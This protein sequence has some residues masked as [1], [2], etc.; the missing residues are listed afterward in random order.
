MQESDQPATDRDFLLWLLD[1]VDPGCRS[2]HEVTVDDG[3]GCH[4]HVIFLQDI[5]M[6]KFK[7]STS[8]ND[9]GFAVLIEAE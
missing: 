7:L 6:K 4:S 8:A 1:A 5:G 2:D 9:E 3:R